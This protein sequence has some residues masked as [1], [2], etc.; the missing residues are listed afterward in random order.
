MAI[1]LWS[2]RFLVNIKKID[3][4]HRGLV[5]AINELHDAMQAGQ[6]RGAV[7]ATLDKLVKYTLTHFADEE[8]LMKTHEFPGYEEHKRQHDILKQKV[9]RLRN[10]VNDGGVLTSVEML[11]FLI[12]WLTGHILKSDKQYG[13]FLW[14]KGVH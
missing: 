3:E 11:N 2:E 6:G 9:V 5:L 1:F 10:D 4:Q 14:Y 13:P 8:E 12:D 7:G